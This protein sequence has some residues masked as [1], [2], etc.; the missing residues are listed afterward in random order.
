MEESTDTITEFTADRFPPNGNGI[1][2][3]LSSRLITDAG[4]FTAL[5]DTWDEL[6]DA[7]PTATIFQSHTW[8][9]LWWK[10][11]S[12]R[13]DRLMIILF[14]QNGRLV[15]AAPLFLRTIRLAG[16][17]VQRQ[18]RL[19]G[20]GEVFGD[21]F[22]FFLDDGPSDYLDILA[23]S[24]YES[25]LIAALETAIGRGPVSCDRL[26]LLNVPEGSPLRSLLQGTGDAPRFTGGAT[27]A[28]IC[29]YLPAPASK[30]E[31]LRNLSPNIRRKFSQLSRALTTEKLFRLRAASSR[32]E[33]IEILDYL[34]GLHQRRWNRLGYPGLFAKPHF[35]EFFHDLCGRLFDRGQLWCKMAEDNATVFGARIAFRSNASYFDYL[36]GFDDRSPMTRHR[37]GF[38]LLADMLDDAIATKSREINFLRG[39]ESYK[40]ELTSAVR[41]NVNIVLT[42]AKYSGTL[43]YYLWRFVG[44]A[45]LALTLLRRERD[46]LSVQF[47]Q[48]PFHL[49]LFRYFGFRLPKFAAKFNRLTARAGNKRTEGEEN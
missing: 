20:S 17:S 33:A 3:P 49:F 22:G 27:E 21:T 45:G 35:A 48:H 19:L 4:E 23:L 32:A 18:L 14:H 46:L 36:S 10:H 26:E 43:R 16:F 24:G 38:A 28:D 12:R 37:P 25:R 8:L 30:E 47:A 5:A 1:R 29:P 13:S 11:F 41:R 31:Y 6:A 39:D 9:T 44:V 7:C 15:G 42:S 2:P 40:F 34:I